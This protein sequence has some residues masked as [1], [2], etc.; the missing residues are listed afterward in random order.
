MA[1]RDAWFGT[2]AEGAPRMFA[3]SKAD[4]IEGEIV[5]LLEVLGKV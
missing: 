1:E 2:T 4:K 3:L 5:I